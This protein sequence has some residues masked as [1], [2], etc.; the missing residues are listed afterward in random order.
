ME[1]PNICKGSSENDKHALSVAPI[2][3]PRFIP[4][5]QTT[6]H[7]FFY[8]GSW[9]TDY[10]VDSPIAWTSVSACSHSQEILSLNMNNPFKP[11]QAV[12]IN[13]GGKALS[14]TPTEIFTNY[15]S[16]SP[17]IP[18]GI[19]LYRWNFKY[20][21]VEKVDWIIDFFNTQGYDAENPTVPVTIHSFHQN[22]ESALP[23][24]TYA[25]RNTDEVTALMVHPRIGT[26]C[27]GTPLG[28]NV[29]SGYS[30]LTAETV[31]FPYPP[32]LRTSFTW[33]NG[34]SVASDP[35]NTQNVAYWTAIGNDPANVN[36]MR[37][38]IVPFMGAT[39]G[40]NAKVRPQVRV[41]AKFTITWRDH[42]AND[43]MFIN[44][45]RVTGP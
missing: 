30:G 36:R 3:I 28:T 24:L 42:A 26:I 40:N 12:W 31:V 33:K 19:N 16:S 14:S 15:A 32:E 5:A 43:S 44:L 17:Y 35:T 23:T 8:V 9:Q 6:T 34:T 11:I 29:V 22:N 4:V 2:S 37:F 38:F 27:G 20:Y 7:D 41:R 25:S 39:Y 21:K 13:E 10:T 1:A 45:D 18:Q